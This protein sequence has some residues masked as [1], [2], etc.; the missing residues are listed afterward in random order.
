MIRK[1]DTLVNHGELEG[2]DCLYSA[3]VLNRALL[4]LVQEPMI[5]TTQ[6]QLSRFIQSDGL[7]GTVFGGEGFLFGSGV[8]V[9]TVAVVAGVAPLESAHRFTPPFGNKSVTLRPRALAIF[10]FFLAWA[11][12]IPSR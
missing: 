8:A 10:C 1:N 12:N 6:I 7:T 2:I 3:Q 5:L 11:D 4:P 9:P